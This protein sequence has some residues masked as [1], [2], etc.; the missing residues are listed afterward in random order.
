MT[1]PLT[2]AMRELLIDAAA[3]LHAGEDAGTVLRE[4]REYLRGQAE[5]IA[6]A[7]GAYEGDDAAPDTIRRE[8]LRRITE[9]ENER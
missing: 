4:R 6:N 8:I 7:T 9:R 5:L 3:W 2:L 1:H